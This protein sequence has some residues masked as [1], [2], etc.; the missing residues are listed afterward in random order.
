MNLRNIFA[1]LLLL[2]A[3]SVF[4]QDGD[5]TIASRDNYLGGKKNG[6]WQYYDGTLYWKG[7]YVNGL[8]QG[9]WL[10][11]DKERE[12]H[13]LYIRGNFTDD[14]ADGKWKML[15]DD[16][17]LS[18]AG[19]IKENQL[20]GIWKTRTSYGEL[21][22]NPDTT[23]P[24]FD[25]R[26]LP[27]RI[28]R[29]G[30]DCESLYETD[31]KTGK[32]KYFYDGTVSV[33]SEGEYINGKKEGTWN[34]YHFNGVTEYS[35]VY[36]HGKKEGEW[37]EYYDN[38]KIKCIERYVNGLLNGECSF[39]T[40][41]GILRMTGR[42]ND[43]YRSGVWK[44][45]SKD[46]VVIQQGCYDG[47]QDN[48]RPERPPQGNRCGLEESKYEIEVILNSD[49]YYLPESNRQGAWEEN[50]AKGV[51]RQKGSYINGKKSGPWENYTPDGC[52][53]SVFNYKDGLEDGEF[54]EFNWHWAYVWREGLCKNGKTM[55]RKEYRE[56][57]GPRKEEYFKNKGYKDIPK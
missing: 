20:T 57:E 31:N 51:L 36:H 48:P 4:A 55:S 11:Y 30:Q 50:Y 35:G 1:G 32:W 15:N 46:S 12:N 33:S 53:M 17:S 45:Y 18:A 39:F 42:F 44:S 9:T 27:E 14:Y 2:F 47:L 8:K 13:Q 22:M 54:V 41:D 38:G 3:C 5:T 25:I 24:D 40:N 26:N 6:L 52:L 21:K 10:C 49:S 28:Y 43:G 56:G 23:F 19:N 29:I 37:K 7:K 34:Y 16:G